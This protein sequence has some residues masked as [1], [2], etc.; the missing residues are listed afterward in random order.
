MI[1]VAVDRQDQSYLSK[2]TSRDLPI[3]SI[4]SKSYLKNKNR[5]T[6][7]LLMTMHYTDLGTWE[8]KTWLEWIITFFNKNYL[9]HS[10]LWRTLRH[11]HYQVS[12]F[13]R[14]YKR[15]NE[16]CCKTLHISYTVQAS[17]FCLTLDIGYTILHFRHY[18]VKKKSI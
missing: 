2:K 8:C 9:L 6:N 11:T 1:E 12:S 5:F 4:H 14:D 10:T 7:V 16:Y 3:P 15:L 18:R 13:H 17:V